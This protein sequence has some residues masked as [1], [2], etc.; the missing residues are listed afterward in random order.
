MGRGIVMRGAVLLL[1]AVALFPGCRDGADGAAPERELYTVVA[2]DFE[3]V[4]ASRQSFH[5]KG[6]TRWPG[7]VTSRAISSQGVRLRTPGEISFEVRAE[8]GD[9]LRLSYVRAEPTEE[10]SDEPADISIRVQSGHAVTTPAAVT[11]EWQQI[12]IDLT[13]VAGTVS[14]ITIN[15]RP[16]PGDV[17]IGQVLHLR[18]ATVARPNVILY[19]E[20]TLRADHLGSYGYE[21]PT[22]PHLAR[23]AAE[24]VQ[25]TRAFAA[26]N[27]T[28]PAVSTLLTGLDPGDHGNTTEGGRI[29]DVASTLAELYGKAG[30]VTAAFVTNIHAGPWSGLDRGFDLHLDRKA[31]PRS[32]R[33]S[34]LTSGLINDALFEF[35]EQHDDELL[36]VYVHSTDPHE[37]Y[38]SLS[39]DLFAVMAAGSPAAPP[40]LPDDRREQWSEW[41]LHYDGEVHHNDRSLRQLDE[42][43][44][45]LGLKQDTLLAFTS[46]HGEAFAEHERWGHRRTMHQEELGVPWVLRWPAALAG[47]VVL[48]EPVGHVD[49]GPTLLGLSGVPAPPAWR[50]RDL[51]ALCRDAGDDGVLP[52]APLLAWGGSG[53]GPVLA[54]VVP[55]WKLVAVPGPDGEPVPVGLYNLELDPEE[56]HDRLREDALRPV[57]DGLLDPLRDLV[58]RHAD[59]SG[60]SVPVEE[61]LTG[62]DE[63]DLDWLRAMGYLK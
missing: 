49:I 44:E 31:F 56:L 38:R 58:A 23:L 55:P 46:D 12:E 57:V 18:R 41:T 13:P 16:G 29:P 51:S 22:D 20:D 2:R 34:S 63:D 37:P 42:H 40:R 4:E 19:L 11:D 7:R 59:S 43:L 32:S 5:A 27:W 48:D 30:Y 50:G 61:A 35:L 8:A 45:T 21:R 28:R 1:A 36:F 39:E 15:L 52:A 26:S 24:G 10:S 3:F 60:D 54:C 6:L 9:R 25:F 14:E 62:L 53:E 17:L 47:G 33:D